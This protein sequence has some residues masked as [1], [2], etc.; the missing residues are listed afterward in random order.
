MAK[1]I[2][3]ESG[4]ETTDALLGDYGIT[5]RADATVRTTATYSDR[6]MQEAQ[7]IMALTHT[8][9]PL[10][11]GMNT[12]LINPDFSG[13]LPQNSQIATPNTVLTTPLHTGQVAKDGTPMIYSTP[14]RGVD[15]FSKTPGAATPAMRDSLS[16]N[17][18][19]MMLA[20]STPAQLKYQ[21]RQLTS[22]LREGLSALPEP[23]ND[24]EI[25]VPEEEHHTE[26]TNNDNDIVMDQSDVDASIIETEKELGKLKNNSS[27]V[28]DPILWGNKIIMVFGLIAERIAL[29]RRSKVFQRSLP[30]PIE[31]NMQIIRPPNELQD[32]TEHQKAE[33]LIK[34]EMISMMYYDEMKNPIPVQGK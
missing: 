2:V 22:V 29:S 21:Q 10:K 3:L 1:E 4:I 30:R 19:D 17:Q 20:P 31:V 32:L 24:Y 12:P 16:I 9:T 6:I 25:V 8:D 14:G 28:C 18:D 23:K 15:R 5:P 33:E 7:N 27:P 13:S 11:G 34:R 26:E